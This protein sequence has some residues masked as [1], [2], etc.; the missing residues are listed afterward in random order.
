MISPRVGGPPEAMREVVEVD[1]RGARHDPGGRTDARRGAD[2]RPPFGGSGAA[3][4]DDLPQRVVPLAA[5]ALEAAGRGG[6]GDPR[7][8]VDDE[9]IDLG[10]SLLPGD[11]P[12]GPDVGLGR[13]LRPGR[14][15]HEQHGLGGDARH[16]A[17]DAGD[18]DLVPVGPEHVECTLGLLPDAGEEAVNVDVA[19][20]VVQVG[21]RVA[22]R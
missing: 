3:L 2:S 16:L 14:V 15:E 18:L 19:P 8:E 17:S 7:V 22:E 12:G 10:T 9:R 20:R 4:G 21:L 5:V 13:V 11:P 1:E 6:E